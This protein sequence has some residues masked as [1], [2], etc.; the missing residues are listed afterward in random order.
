VEI[1][2]TC[3]QVADVLS[4]ELDQCDLPSSFRPLIEMPL[5]QRGKALSGDP[6]PRWPR[7]VLST[8]IATGGDLSVGVRVAAAVEAFLAGADVIDDIQDGDQSPFVDSVGRPQA[9]N[10]AAALLVLAHAILS[11][12]G[13][14]GVPL[15]RVPHF[16]RVL[17]DGAL[18]AAGGQHLDLVAEGSRS[19]GPSEA[20]AIV[21]AKAGALGG[22]ATRLGGLVGTD[23]AALLDLYE[24]FGTHIGVIA[25]INNDLHDAQWAHRKSDLVREKRTLP[26]VY[27]SS[28]RH[29]SSMRA[30]EEPDDFTIDSETRAFIQVVLTAELHRAR[31]VVDALADQGQNVAPLV[32]LLDF[33]DVEQL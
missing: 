28:S 25:Q 14:H 19:I 6:D 11:R 30:D 27:R 33:R 9:L 23:D 29:E 7:L 3:Q 5:R 1:A 32:Q 2:E 24:A 22:M 21:Q 12:L 17:S 20:Y 18:R 8:C 10:A 16:T 31:A 26:L 15:H 13:E 4:T